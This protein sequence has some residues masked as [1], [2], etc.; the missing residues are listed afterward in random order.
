MVGTA[1]PPPWEWNSAFD[2]SPIHDAGTYHFGGCPICESS[3]GI[4][5]VRLGLAGL[6]GKAQLVGVVA[7]LGVE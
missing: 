2:C 5:L 1:W 3:G 6:A 7:A 4:G